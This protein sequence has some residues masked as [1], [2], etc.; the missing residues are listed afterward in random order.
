MIPANCMYKETHQVSKTHLWRSSQSCT[1]IWPLATWSLLMVALGMETGKTLARV[2]AQP[3]KQAS[4][5]ARTHQGQRWPL[6]LGIWGKTFPKQWEGPAQINKKLRLGQG[7]LM[8][9]VELRVQIRYTCRLLA[10]A[11]QRNG[12]IKLEAMRG[13]WHLLHVIGS[14]WCCL[15]FHLIQS[16]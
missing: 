9:R 7:R 2:T 16:T 3:A 13:L 4:D 5:K 12:I 8:L 10:G 14:E 11:I 1:I 6:R 15:T